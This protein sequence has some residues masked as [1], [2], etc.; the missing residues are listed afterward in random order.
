MLSHLRILY[1][2]HLQSIVTPT[3]QHF[4]TDNGCLGFSCLTSLDTLV[5]GATAILAII[6]SLTGA[7][8][9]PATRQRNRKYEPGFE[10]RC[11]MLNVWIVAEWMGHIEG[12]VRFKTQLS[13]LT[14]QAFHHV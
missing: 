11:V 9:A 7:P 13:C 1:F 10:K 14:C 8:T 5:R 2:T 6:T 4:S 12:N 3:E